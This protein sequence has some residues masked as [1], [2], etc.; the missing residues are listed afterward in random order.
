MTLELIEDA[1]GD[2]RNPMTE[3][4]VLNKFRSNAKSVLSEKQSEELVAAVQHL[5]TI[6]SVRKIIDLL[7][8][9]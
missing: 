5:E 9:K 7:M 6:D 2:P 4:E 8:P 3:E 1:K